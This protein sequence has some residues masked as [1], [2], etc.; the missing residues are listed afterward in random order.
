[1]NR[2]A[3][4]LVELLNYS[5]SRDRALFLQK[6]E[7]CAMV[8]PTAVGRQYFSE[9]AGSTYGTEYQSYREEEERFC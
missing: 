1:M 7:E 4:T 8:F 3:T 2:L 5:S 9:R 6:G